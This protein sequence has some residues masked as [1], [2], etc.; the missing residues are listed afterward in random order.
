MARFSKTDAWILWSVAADATGSTL[1]D[2]IARAD[3]VNHAIPNRE[4]VESA[5][6]KG[7]QVGLLLT[8]GRFVRYAPDRVEEVKKIVA[9]ARRAFDSWTDLH[10]FLAGRE[11]PHACSTSVQIEEEAMQSAYSDYIKK[12]KRKKGQNQSLEPTPGKCPFRIQ[13]PVSGVGSS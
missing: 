7:L 12:L 5:V 2:I 1:T 8:D 4:E 3:Y 11:W 10:G 13:S 6:S 9:K